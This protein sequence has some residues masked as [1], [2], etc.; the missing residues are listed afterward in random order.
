MV[1]SDFNLL[2]VSDLH[3]SEGFNPHTGKLSPN[4]DFIS[5]DSFAEF[6]SYHDTHRAE[7]LPWRLVIAGDVFDFLQVTTPSSSL[8]DEL[9]IKIDGLEEGGWGIPREL[10]KPTDR[11][12]KA[13][14]RLNDV[15]DYL[16][17]HPTAKHD[18]VKYE[19]T[20]LNSIAATVALDFVW[21]L[22]QLVLETWILALKSEAELSKREKEYG[23]G[24]SWPEA[25]WKIDRIAE[26][27]PRFFAA[28]SKFIDQGNSVVMMRGNHDVELFWEE[29]QHR[30]REL[31]ADAQVLA[32]KEGLDEFTGRNLS[33][34]QFW[35]ALENRFIICHWIY[36]EPGVVYIEH[37]NQYEVVDA[38]E[39]FLYPVLEDP[40]S[41]LRLPPGSFFVRY[42]FNN[43][44]KTFPF[45]DNLR[46]I[47]RFISWAF[48]NHFLKIIKLLLLHSG[49]VWLFTKMLIK[50]GRGDVRHTKK[51]KGLRKKKLIPYGYDEL[52]QLLHA[53]YGH[54][55]FLND[56]AQGPL[57]PDRLSEIINL[58]KNQR[59]HFW[60]MLRKWALLLLPLFLLL[61][62][63]IALL[64]IFVV[65]ALDIWG[66]LKGTFS[67]LDNYLI[68]VVVMGAIGLTVKALVTPV[69]RSLTKMDDYLLEAAW[70]LK[71]ILERPTSSDETAEVPYLVFGHTHDPNMVR[72]G[73]DGPW[74]INTGSW[75]NTINEVE[76]W[77]RLDRDFIFFQIITPDKNILP[78]LFRWNPNTYHPER[79]RIRT[80]ELKTEAE[81]KGA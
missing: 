15:I 27:H 58:A 8:V 50:R 60:A 59:T 9:K 29:V 7:G 79:I 12:Q 57:T 73:E 18:K 62:T 46:P 33:S 74:Y 81:P 31:I 80:G 22:E 24:T 14:D 54:R 3:L 25:V 68:R 53:D 43:V 41:Y 6:L 16:I 10:D 44:E 4:E 67:Y 77:S 5:D 78:G 37:G 40:S 63:A 47:S 32:Q 11:R 13:I 39:D 17:S 61:A 69:L 35:V 55:F 19:A 71:D 65:P 72:L 23:L 26:G 52:I 48:D 30:L 75:L 64:F 49:G 66:L 21:S 20:R 28:L 45:A 38:F 56:G 76:S 34:D 70:K 36:Y 1:Y 42:L 51:V 2:V